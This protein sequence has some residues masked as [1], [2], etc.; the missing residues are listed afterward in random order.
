MYN[1]P[2]NM[3]IK[4]KKHFQNGELNIEFDLEKD[5][6]LYC[7]KCYRI[8]LVTASRSVDKGRADIAK[9]KIAPLD[10]H[11][12]RLAGLHTDNHSGI[13]K[14]NTCDECHKYYPNGEMNLDMEF[15]TKPALFCDKCYEMFLSYQGI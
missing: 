6:P 3:C 9:K 12:E 10:A 8:F 2:G 7:N 1:N 15:S 13:H 4:C 5:F 11:I 14:D